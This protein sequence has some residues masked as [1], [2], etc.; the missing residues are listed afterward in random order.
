MFLEIGCIAWTN[1][2]RRN[3]R[4]PGT[5]PPLTRLASGYLPAKRRT[6]QLL[7]VYLVRTQKVPF[8]QS[9]ANW[10]VLVLDAVAVVLSLTIPFTAVGADLG[11]AALPMA[12]LVVLPAVL[13]GYVAL[14]MLIR[15][16]Y[17]R[18]YGSLL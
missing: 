14:V 15:W 18:R 11:F 5:C 1:N 13:A 6:R 7:F 17:L 12:F 16:L 3:K 10:R 8:F 2:S 9:M 4:R